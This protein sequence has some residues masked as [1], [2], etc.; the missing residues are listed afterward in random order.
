VDYKNLLIGILVSLIG[1]LFIAYISLERKEGD[2]GGYG[3]HIKMYFGALVFIVVGFIMILS[4][5][6][7]VL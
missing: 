3:A 1:I 2:K 5:L 4:E 7:K 6:L